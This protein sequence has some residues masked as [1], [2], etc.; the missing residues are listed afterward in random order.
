MADRLDL[1]RELLERAEDDER[2]ACA[3]VPV[4]EVSNAIVCFHAQEAVEKAIK[5][6]LAMRGAEFPFTHN[7]ALLLQLCADAGIDVPR[8]PGRG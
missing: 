1:A 5:A 4:S 6:V 8:R 7:L 3:L 2:A